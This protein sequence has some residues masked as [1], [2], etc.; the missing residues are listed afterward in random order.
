MDTAVAL[1]EAYLQINGYLC[2]AE[3]PLLETDPAGE[4]RMVSD[5]DV[6]A[7]RFPHAGH[8]VA[9]RGDRELAGDTRFE[10]DPVLG[11]DPAQPDMIVGEVKRGRARFNPATRR[12]EVLA[13]ALMRF[14]CCTPTEALALAQRLV[15]HGHAQSHHGHAIRMIAFGSSDPEDTPSSW[16]VV[17][18]SAIVR[19]L[20]EHLSGQWTRLKQVQFG[21]PSL[22]LLALLE[23][24]EPVDGVRQGTSSEVTR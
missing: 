7:F 15:R 1:V 9:G 10:P 23:R 14:G 3:Y 19:G 12:P 11:A 13:A 21:N 20:R 8:E 6:L 22:D 17:P 5:L 18:L 24:I 2:V 16:R 4:V